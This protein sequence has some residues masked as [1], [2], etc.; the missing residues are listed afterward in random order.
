[1]WTELNCPS[2][3]HYSQGE[4]TLAK[5]LFNLPLWSILQELYKIFYE[6][7]CTLSHLIINFQNKHL[8]NRI[9]AFFLIL[10]ILGILSQLSTPC[11]TG[12]LSR[13]QNKT[14]QKSKVSSVNLFYDICAVPDINSIIKSNIKKST[15]CDLVSWLAQIWS[16]LDFF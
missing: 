3:D 4:I 9:L 13:L 6:Y 5:T 14:K 12:C 7:I 8:K 2:L 1:M 11:I 10:I 15:T 16:N